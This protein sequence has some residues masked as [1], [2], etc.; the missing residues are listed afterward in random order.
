MADRDDPYSP[1]P[2]ARWYMVAAVASLLFM[3]VGCAGYL[4]DVT[5]DPTAIPLD[6]RALYEARPQWQVAA[7]GI[8]VWVGL[9]GTILLILRRRLA[10]PALLVSLVA[11]I[12]TFLPFAIVPGV[13]D[14]ITTN[15]IAAAV[16]VLLITGTIYSFARHSRMRGWLR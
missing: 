10:E 6:Q 5:M 11:A 15:D 1:R 8:A 16:I 3:I 7:Y 9:V 4:L 14:N 13:R 2:I 12:F